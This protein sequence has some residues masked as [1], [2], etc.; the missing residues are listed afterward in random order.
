MTPRVLP[1]GF[2]RGQ[3]ECRKL[4]L[5]RT[6]AVVYCPQCSAV[7]TLTDYSVMNDGTVTPVFSCLNGCRFEAFIQLGGWPDR[8]GGREA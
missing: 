5:D 7:N 3:W 6:T 8:D 2:K 4:S 1:R